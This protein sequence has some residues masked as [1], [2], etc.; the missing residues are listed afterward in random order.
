MTGPLLS[1]FFQTAMSCPICGELC[2]CAEPRSYVSRDVSLA[3][4]D[5]YDPSEEQ[6]ASSVGGYQADVD[7]G[8]ASGSLAAAQERYSS[9][10]P[11]Q[12]LPS[13]TMSSSSPEPEAW[14][15]EVASCL[16][17]YKARRRRSLGDE[18]LSFNFESTTGNH[19]FL[20]P[21]PVAASYQEPEPVATYYGSPYATAHAF[22]E[23]TSDSE[24]DD[25][26]D[27]PTTEPQSSFVDFQP[28]NFEES[29]E[30][31]DLRESQAKHATVP[32]TAKLLLFPRPPVTQEFRLDELAETLFETP[33][34]VEAPETVVEAVAVP[35][36]DI[37]LHPE[38]EEDRC[39]P[40]IEPVTELLVEVA[41]VGQRVFAEMLDTAL[42][43]VATGIFGLILIR[44]N[45]VAQDK[46]ALYGLLALIPATFWA[47]YK[48][49]FLVH[50]GI[51]PGMKM[52]QLRLVH[53]DGGLPQKAPRRYRA[54]AML[55]S[56][57]PL[58]LGL[59]WSFVDP[60]TLC[61]HDRISRTYMTAR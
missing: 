28:P 40:Y 36:A 49:L 41:P 31:H 55:V 12:D 22:E 26:M 13:S 24:V 50:G 11:Q 7:Q 42:V 57:F 10:R 30:K 27:Q 16:Q 14:R 60:D 23:F 15:E 43:A 5:A 1:A 4:V 25:L 20:K 54:L 39:V 59:W 17:S 29:V 53:F 56:I 37:T 61:W 58:G 52:A 19:V 38:Q 21:E 44:M 35:L 2:R 46:H 3:E 51:T 6:F 45:A 33:R 8:L 47:I 32:E 34:I 9:I 18:S 48:Y